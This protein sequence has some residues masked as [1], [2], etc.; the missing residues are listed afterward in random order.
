MPMLLIC[1]ITIAV[2][3]TSTTA[4]IITNGGTSIIAVSASITGVALS[5]LRLLSGRF[6][7]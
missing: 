3:I 2:A 7:L 4:T 6:S 1:S 5:L